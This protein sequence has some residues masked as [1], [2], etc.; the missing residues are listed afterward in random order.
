M[1]FNWLLATSCK[2]LGDPAQFE[3]TWSDFL[4]WHLRSCTAFRW[5]VENLVETHRTRS[6]VARF[7]IFCCVS[8][9][10]SILTVSSF[11][12]AT[13]QCNH[14]WLNPRDFNGISLWNQDQTYLPQKHQNHW[15]I[16]TMTHCKIIS[17]FLGMLIVFYVMSNQ[18]VCHKCFN[19]GKIWQSASPL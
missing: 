3:R 8:V 7:V 15:L 2:T 12:F 17:Y 14:R 18:H 4:A 11:D 16:L 19:L 5:R 6:L 1:P 9:C 13:C 10:F